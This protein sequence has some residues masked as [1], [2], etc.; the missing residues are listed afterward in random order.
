M[1]YHTLPSVR[2]RNIK[3]CGIG[4]GGSERIK[5][6]G[7]GVGRST[8]RLIPWLSSRIGRIA[9]AIARSR[10]GKEGR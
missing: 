2:E 9:K 8:S 10:L 5:R 1:V 3:A 4:Y 6:G 7:T